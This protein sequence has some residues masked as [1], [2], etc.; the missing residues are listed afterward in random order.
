MAPFRN[1]FSGVLRAEP[2]AFPRYTT[3]FF[4]SPYPFRALFMTSRS[5]RKLPAAC[6]LFASILVELSLVTGLVSGPTFQRVFDLSE[7]QLGVALSA[8]YVGL[9]LGAAVA[10]QLTHSRGPV[11]SLCVGLGMELISMALVNLAPGFYVLVIGLLGVGAAAGLVANANITLLGDL[12]PT[13]VREVISLG[14][15]LWFG[16]S[17]FSAPLIGAWLEHAWRRGLGAWSYRGVYLT[18]VLLMGLALVL[19]VVVIRPRV[20]PH[21]APSDASNGEGGGVTWRQMWL[22]ALGFC[23]GL[24]VIVLMAWMNPLVQQKFG[25]GDLK[26]GVAMGAVACGLGA[27][28]LLFARVRSAAD[29][30]KFIAISALLGGVFFLGGL[31]S[32]FYLL[33]LVGVAG[34]ALLSCPVGPCIMALPRKLFATEKARVLSYYQAAIAVAGLAGPSLVGTLADSGVPI[35]VGVC[36]SPLAAF[37]MAAL[38]FA[39]MRRE[40]VGDSRR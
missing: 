11:V 20:P 39:W 27:G 23:Q 15:A 1:G 22:P 6:I 38:A 12:F 30:R 9:L 28:R 16:S 36:I 34:G 18:E 25:V 40:P 33:T 37:A 35:W 14:S 8:A 31:L 13:R 29:D 24:M 4:V 17:T 10:G 2:G 19:A 26:G 3:G 7:T 32:P 21:E 5:S